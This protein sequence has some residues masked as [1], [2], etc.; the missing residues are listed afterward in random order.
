MLETLSG[1]QDDVGEAE[2]GL[3]SIGPP[4]PIESIAHAWLLPLAG[5][6]V[7]NCGIFGV[8]M[9]VTKL[10]ASRC[11]THHVC[12]CGA[13]RREQ[14]ETALQVIQVWAEVGTAWPDESE[15]RGQLNQ[16]AHK[17]KQAL[18]AKP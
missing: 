16:I 10:Q 4:L 3:S 17:A 7:E 14:L 8:S 11:Q 5:Y 6:A 13:W 15:V 9:S 12:Q 18:E 1:T 2:I